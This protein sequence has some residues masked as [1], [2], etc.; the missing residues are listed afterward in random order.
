MFADDDTSADVRTSSQSRFQPMY[1]GRRLITKEEN[2]I[3]VISTL[4]SAHLGFLGFDI[5]AEDGGADQADGTTQLLHLDKMRS[6][7]TSNTLLLFPGRS[8]IEEKVDITK[9]SFLA[10]NLYSTSRDLSVLSVNTNSGELNG[11]QR[12]GESGRIRK[13]ASKDIHSSTLQLMPLSVSPEPRAFDCGADHANDFRR[14]TMIDASFDYDDYSQSYFK[15]G[16]NHT[17]GISSLQNST[18]PQNPLDVDENLNRTDLMDTSNLNS[19]SHDGFDIDIHYEGEYHNSTNL[20]DTSNSQPV[21]NETVHNDEGG[22]N[23][24]TDLI[25]NPDLST[26]SNETALNGFEID[27]IVDID[28]DLIVQNGGLERAI[29][30]VN[31]I[32]STTNVILTKEFDLHLNVVQISE[33][34]IFDN[35]DGGN[36]TTRDA[37]KKMRQTYQGTVGKN[38]GAHLRHAL[39]GKELGG[40]IAFTDTVCNANWGFAISSGLRGN[41]TNMD[42][43]DVFIFAHELGHNLGSGEYRR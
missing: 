18:V 6:A 26:V 35:L 43:Y 22:Y 25:H 40:G 13:I 20:I 2:L 9:I 7:V 15:G 11:I 42:M 30:Y 17:V 1:N 33:T 34:D 37:L 31:F 32:V 36:G 4:D 12:H 10:S 19:L 16:G 39:L 27:L 29:E 14:M 3:D 28:R 23:N 41:V 24:S 5:E 8:L 21:S 38:R